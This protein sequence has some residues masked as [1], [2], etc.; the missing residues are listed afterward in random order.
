MGAGGGFLIVPALALWAGLPMPAA[1]GTS[2]L[3]IVMNTLAGFSGYA[4]HVHVDYRLVAGVA[5]AAVA[6]SFGG[7][8]LANRVDPASLRRAFACFV[9]A[10]AAFVMVR[11]TG[12]WIEVAREALPRSIAQLGFVLLVLA[13]GVAA[14]RASR[15]G[16]AE[17]A[18]DRAFEQGAGI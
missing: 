14:G 8:R 11:E 2:L 17:P 18:T 7:A 3:V 10:M 4:S 13:A 9:L 5:A 6:G 12:A 15:R 16:G 1:V